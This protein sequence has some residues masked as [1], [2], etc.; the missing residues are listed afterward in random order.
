MCHISGEKP[1]SARYDA[2]LTEDDRRDYENI[3]ILCPTHHNMI[4]NLEPEF[5]TVEVLEKMKLEAERHSE[6]VDRSRWPEDLVHKAAIG[7][8]LRSAWLSGAGDL[9]PIDSVDSVETAG[10]I[11]YHPNAESTAM[12]T[13]T[14]ADP[15]LPATVDVLFD[16][17]PEPTI[18]TL[19]Q[20]EGFR[21]D[22]DRLDEGRLG[23][24]REEFGAAPGG[25]GSQSPYGFR[26]D[27][28]SAER[29]ERM[30]MSIRQILGYGAV[31]DIQPD[32]G[33]AFE[34]EITT[35]GLTDAQGEQLSA[36]AT[37]D[38]EVLNVKTSSDRVITIRPS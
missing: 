6:S 17:G 24:S 13:G 19:N 34:V 3:I 20:A 8:V 37:E 36:L 32:G 5:F 21:L 28:P 38:G 18:G 22:T 25:F 33:R 7:L 4:D 9:E 1:N 10:V 27:T 29:D 12:A 16:T 11:T 26:N 2:N 31:R 35:E 23:G 15:G 30:K 14:V